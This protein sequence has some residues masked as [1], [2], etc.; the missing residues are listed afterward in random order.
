MNQHGA[1]KRFGQHFLHDPA[2]IRRI[3]DAVDPRPGDHLI[4]IGPG[5]GAITAPILARSGRLKVVE[6]DPDVIAELQAV[7]EQHSGLEIHLADALKT[8]YAALAP[9]GEPIRL[10]GNLPYNISTPLLFHLLGQ[11]ALVQDMTFMLQKEVVDRMVAQPGGKDYGRLSVS[12]AARADVHALFEVG[13]G[14]FNPPPQVESAVV[15]ILP[16]APSFEVHDWKRFDLIVSAAFS[17]RR[18]QLANSL[19]QWVSP[20]QLR[21]LDIDPKLRAESL[22]PEQFA[23]ISNL[24]SEV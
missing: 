3:V 5:R 21:A 9:T 7:C 12:L 23:R 18:K 13:K 4:E 16:R 11:S 22:A 1:K 14:A 2:V 6:I 17:Q 15:Q 8:D 20:Q 10:L 19:K 24:L